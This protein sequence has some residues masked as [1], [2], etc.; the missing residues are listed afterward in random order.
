VE[1]A[2]WRDAVIAHEDLPQLEADVDRLYAAIGPDS[3]QLEVVAAIRALLVR[4][5]AAPDLVLYCYGD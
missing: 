5:R 3:P 4:W 1:L 2:P